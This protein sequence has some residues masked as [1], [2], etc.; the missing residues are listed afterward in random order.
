MFVIFVNLKSKNKV[1]GEV[2]A[3]NAFEAAREKRYS[4]HVITVR[5][6]YFSQNE[7]SLT[8]LEDT[9]YLAIYG[10][11]MY[12]MVPTQNSNSCYVYILRLFETTQYGY[13]NLK[14]ESV[15]TTEHIEAMNISSVDDLLSNIELLFF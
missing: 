9:P 11:T 12:L 2:L 1:I 8:V 7:N 14:W 10:Q 13:R 6:A 15:L 5:D 4:S 3:L